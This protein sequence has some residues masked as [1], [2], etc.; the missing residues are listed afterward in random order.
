[1][2]MTFRRVWQRVKSSLVMLA[3]C[4]GVV[5]AAYAALFSHYRDI[6]F[7]DNDW[8]YALEAKLLDFKLTNR[9]PQKTSGKVGILAIDEKSI[10]QFGRWPFSRKYHEKAFI[11]LKKLGVA[12]IGFDA[13]YDTAEKTI[14]E[15][16]ERQIRSMPKA[17]MLRKPA[18]K[19]RA[20]NVDQLTALLM[21]SPSDLSF[22][23]G[24]SHFGNIVQ[25]YFYFAGQETT[26]GTHRQPFFGLDS[27]QLSE[28]VAIDLPEGRSLSDYRSLERPHA[29]TTNH[30]VLASASQHFGFFSNDADSDAINRWL[31][32]AANIDGKLMPSLALKTAAEAL[33]SDILVTFDRDIGIEKISLVG[34][35]DNK[36]R[37][38]PVDPLGTGRL[39]INHRGPSRTF[40]HFSLADA[41]NNTFTDSERKKLKGMTLLY[42]ATAT[43]INDM[44]PNPYDPGVDGVENHAAAI[45][46]IFKGDFLR[47]PVDV[48]AT[49]LYIVL[50][51]GLLF[52]PLV[53]WGRA[54]V[55]AIA[56][57][58]FL[59]GYYYV[60]KY[61]WF[62]RGIWAFMV[63]PC[64]EISAMFI[65]TTFY[66]Y[67]VEERARKQI[68]GTFEQY[69]SKDVI[70]QVLV[71]PDSQKLGGVRRDVTVFFSDVRDFTTISEKLS[72]EK[73]GELMNLYFN[74]TTPHVLK[75]GGTLDKFIGDAIM[76]FWGAPLALA[77]QADRACQSS[78][79]ILYAVDKLRVDLPK[80]GLPA[81]DMG[82]GLNSGMASVGNFGSSQR[83]CY[84]AMGDT[85]NLAA[86][87]EGLTK[88]FGVKILISE[89]TRAQL[90]RQDFFMRDLA[91]ITVKGK[92]QPVRI[93]ELMRPDY[94]QNEA[95]LRN[96]I[97]EFDE[98]R[99][100]F[101]ARDWGKAEKFFMNCLKI[102]PDDVPTNQYLE[103]IAEFKV[104]EPAANW[105][106]VKRFKTK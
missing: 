19:S 22:A 91:V 92:D 84:T 94:L 26:D 54:L 48:Y 7:V 4:V 57:L 83:F 76:A 27:M 37:V 43:G 25:G 98:A 81:V 6:N 49:E 11:N 93:F 104:S 105:D 56:V 88:Q 106:G 1:M 102:K 52:A 33:N 14:L 39:L 64:A 69:L 2:L 77:D 100:N 68:K 16:V 55:S 82:I 44:R 28:I 80:V 17:A 96:F 67:V 59:V 70:D 29:I 103:E 13:I 50:G 3:L 46:N 30:P 21:T 65:F 89:F 47:R 62:G 20:G 74:S 72:A 58:V 32:L 31:T 15:D 95:T 60:D 42:G 75:T 45:D 63:V 38:I 66:K 51:I 73:L 35:V 18:N 86:R 9:G 53:I 71:D 24:L 36:E 8:L 101:A 90:K 97:D 5:I 23:R 85:V 78:I 79:E 10:A 40:H 87:L 99:R 41:Y 34:R 61:F 12:W